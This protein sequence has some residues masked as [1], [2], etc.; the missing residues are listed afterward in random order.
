VSFRIGVVTHPARS[1]TCAKPF[2]THLKNSTFIRPS[3]A[4]QD[5]HKNRSCA[6]FYW[7][8]GDLTMRVL[9][10]GGRDY[11]DR[12]T[13][14]CVLHDLA[15]KHGWLTIIEGGARGADAL[16]REWATL[17]RHGLVTIPADWHKHG[18][19]AGPIRNQL[20]IDGGKPDLVVAFPGGRGTADMVRRAK[21]A[22]VKVVEVP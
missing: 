12:E 10:C 2:G 8:F 15:E 16:G 19:G 21:S 13:V 11:S 3:F 4:N 18:T 5:Y 9:V 17:C 22:G 20:M 14:F 7:A 6:R 1:Q